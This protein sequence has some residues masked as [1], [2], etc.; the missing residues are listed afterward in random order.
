MTRVL[1]A[2][3]F[4]ALQTVESAAQAVAAAGMADIV[5]LDYQLP[6]AT[7]LDILASIRAQPSHPSVI[8]VTAHGNESVAAS[9][10]RLGAD[11]YLVKDR[12]LPELLPEVVERVR[13]GRALAAALAAAEGELVR[14]ERLA[15]IGEMTVTLHHEINNPLMSAA[16]MMDLLMHDHATF[17][18]EQQ[19]SLQEVARALDRIRHI[20]RRV[21]TLQQA[22]TRTYVGGTRM[23]DLDAA[24][25]VDAPKIKRGT[26]ALWTRSEET[27]RVVAMLLKREGFS[28]ERCESL[29]QFGKLADM[30]GTT[31]LVAEAGDPS[32][33]DPLG[34]F[35]PRRT[36]VYTFVLL[37][38]EVAD[39]YGADLVVPLPFDPESFTRDVLTSMG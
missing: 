34:G 14:A 13:R 28:V 38:G 37:S 19:E 12:T 17:T 39:E 16:A 32:T 10:L 8:V 35:R 2:H 26:A 31:L 11:D 21:G 23:V 20:V 25:R 3:G 6:D 27:G 29:E 15:A 9:A 36:R 5:L 24:E 33:G 1:A 22:P 4:G 30:L 18:P 7:G